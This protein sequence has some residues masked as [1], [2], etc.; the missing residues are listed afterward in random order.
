[1]LLLITGYALSSSFLSIPLHIYL[2]AHSL[3]LC[4]STSIEAKK[5]DFEQGLA[6]CLVEMQACQ[7]QNRQP[8]NNSQPISPLADTFGII[9]NGN[10]WRF[11]KLVPSG[12]VY[13]TVDYSTAMMEL[14]LGQLR[15]VFMQCNQ[16]MIDR[17]TL[18][19]GET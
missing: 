6:Q 16:I 18:S 1:L 5:D 3:H 17:E 14:L 9:S 11:C 15:Y 10:T 4:Q 8:D 13:Q 12:K 2:S 7:W 19:S